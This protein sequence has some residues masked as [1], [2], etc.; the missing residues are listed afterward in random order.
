MIS[1]TDTQGRVIITTLTGGLY[2]SKDKLTIQDPL[3][4]KPTHD[5]IL[6]DWFG[7][8]VRYPVIDN[9][10]YNKSHPQGFTNDSR[11]LMAV[12]SHRDVIIYEVTKE[13]WKRKFVV[14]RPF[15]YTSEN[16]GGI[17]S[18]AR[19]PPCIAWGYGRTPCFKDRTYSLLAI[20]W[21]SL[22]QIVILNQL[23]DESGNEFFL[24]GHYILAPGTIYKEAENG[25]I[26]DT[27][28]QGMRFLSESL[29][30]VYTSTLDIRVL[31]TQKFE[32]QEFQSP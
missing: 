20:A 5:N 7:N 31:Y 24:D 1:S 16:A 29:L 14:K 4:V 11:T 10:F 15:C 8:Q 22:V 26:Q 17:V 12:G 19:E 30:F 25:V 32:M 3:E 23:D 13:T 27:T 21:G 9:R 18:F 28:I 2:I 6:H